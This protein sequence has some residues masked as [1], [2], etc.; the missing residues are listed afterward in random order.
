VFNLGVDG[1]CTVDE[2]ASWI[3][4]RMGV[5]PTREYTGGERGWV[6]D[7]PF[8]FLDTTKVRGGGWQPRYSIREAVERTVDFLLANPWVVELA[9]QR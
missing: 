4:A 8:I 2:S 6:G 9:G 5:E 7:N 3:C 1:Y